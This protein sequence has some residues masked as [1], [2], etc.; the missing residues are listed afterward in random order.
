MTIGRKHTCEIA[1]KENMHD[2]FHNA[3]NKISSM[4]HTE[5]FHLV[6]KYIIYK[7]I[8]G[9]VN[10]WNTLYI[11]LSYERNFTLNMRISN[12]TILS[13][14]KETHEIHNIARYKKCKFD[15]IQVTNG[16]L[17]MNIT[18]YQKMR[19]YF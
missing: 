4:S 18:K 2:I 7:V 11:Q 9:N 19:S 16:K 6:N 1:T 15:N 12:S 8:N 13:I 3:T 14:V 5:G 17:I 10:F